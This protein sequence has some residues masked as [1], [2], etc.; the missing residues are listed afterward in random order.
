M[1]FDTLGLAEPLLRALAVAGYET[2]TPI[3]SQSIAPLLEGRDM[4][5]LAQ[6]GTGK[7]A[8]FALP[9]LQRLAARHGGAGPKGVKA[10]IESTR[11]FHGV[12]DKRFI[13]TN[14][15]GTAHA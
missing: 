15:F 14:V 2:P 5:G 12:E 6:T 4:M 8:A 1:T 9:I 11:A 7:T 13:I 3:Q 10:L